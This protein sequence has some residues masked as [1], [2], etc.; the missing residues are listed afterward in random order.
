MASLEYSEPCVMERC[1]QGQ[2]RYHQPWVWQSRVPMDCPCRHF[3][4]LTYMTKCDTDT[5]C[6]CP[7]VRLMEWTVASRLWHMA[8]VA[9]AGL[10][11]PRASIPGP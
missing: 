5:Y 6:V 9:P 3:K 11:L 8:A 10:F 4:D 2:G 7:S 1:R